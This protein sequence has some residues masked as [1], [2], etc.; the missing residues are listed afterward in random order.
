MSVMYNNNCIMHYCMTKKT[1]KDIYKLYF[2][3]AQ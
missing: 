3:N 1:V 2:V